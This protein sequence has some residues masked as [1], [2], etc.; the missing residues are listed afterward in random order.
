M[1]NNE[2]QKLMELITYVDEVVNAVGI[3]HIISKGG[4]KS[5]G[6]VYDR[7]NKLMG[8]NPSKSQPI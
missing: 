6:K 2:K 3:N 5:I 1:T 4:G 8:I 7:Y